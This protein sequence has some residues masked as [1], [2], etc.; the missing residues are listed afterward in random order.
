L[1]KTPGFPYCNIIKSAV[2]ILHHPT[3]APKTKLP[4]A[5]KVAREGAK[6]EGKFDNVIQ[7]RDGRIAQVK[8]MRDESLALRMSKEDLN[9]LEN[10]KRFGNS[11]MTELLTDT[12]HHVA[13]IEVK[14]FL[15]WNKTTEALEFPSP[16][17][18]TQSLI[19]APSYSTDVLIG[20][21]FSRFHA[22]IIQ[23]KVEEQRK[24]EGVGAQSPE[25][26]SSLQEQTS[27]KGENLEPTKLTK[28]MRKLQIKKQVTNQL[29]N[30]ADATQS[31]EQPEEEEEDSDRGDNDVD[32]SRKAQIEEALRQGWR[33]EHVS[34]LNTLK[35]YNKFLTDSIPEWEQ[36]ELLMEYLEEFI[37]N[38]ESE[39]CKKKFK[40][41]SSPY[42]NEAENII[43]DFANI[44][45]WFDKRET[46][47]HEAR[48]ATK[49]PQDLTEMDVSGWPEERFRYVRLR[50][51]YAQR[52]AGVKV[53]SNSKSS[54]EARFKYND[55]YEMSYEVLLDKETM[56][57][58]P[59]PPIK[60][61]TLCRKSQNVLGFCEHALKKWYESSD[62]LEDTL[63]SES[64]R[65]HPDRF[66]KCAPSVK[67][68]MVIKAT[69]MFQLI[70]KL[71]I[72]EEKEEVTTSKAK[73]RRPWDWED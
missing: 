27:D 53:P 39:Q 45:A 2:V 12:K 11:S 33:P 56:I 72:V 60:F 34:S 47:I 52:D 26:M 17:G 24:E 9:K 37:D 22:K 16:N 30:R 69:E 65:W 59:A 15:E 48:E 67:V 38:S 25:T 46:A 8:K 43:S 73:G 36:E 1:S 4:T 23:R 3:M 35:R 19:R 20:Q 57:E 63:R 6:E 42:Q 14:Q 44:F 54:K 28:R 41:L 70:G 10:V 21:G 61:C 29:R 50:T 51:R 71:V 58:F 64:R 55:W 7:A 62:D 32:T 66:Q 68:D 18:E 13:A 31:D 5:R 40:K 49:E